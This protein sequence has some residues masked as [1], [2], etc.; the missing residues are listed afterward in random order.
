MKTSNYVVVYDI[1]SDS[2]RRRVEKS[3][4]SF[5]FRVQKSVFECRLTKRGKKALI[6]KLEA[7]NI[8]TGFIKIYRL[9]YSWEKCIIGKKGYETPDED[10]SYIV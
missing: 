9:E 5:G 7:L 4:H 2:E 10:S 8:K 1:S 6:K 3:L